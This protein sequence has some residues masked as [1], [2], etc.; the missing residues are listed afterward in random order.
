MG[1]FKVLHNHASVVH[2]KKYDR[3]VV[4]THNHFAVSGMHVFIVDGMIMPTF[5]AFL[6]IRATETEQLFQR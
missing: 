4:D 3:L 6:G 1:D 2:G 5:C